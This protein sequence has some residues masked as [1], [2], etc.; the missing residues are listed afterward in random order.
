MTEHSFEIHHSHRD[1]T[2][3]WLRPAV[4]GASDGLVSNLALIA[5]VAGGASAA[6][7][8]SSAVV[9][10]GL[11]GLVAGACS[12][13]VGEYV[14]VASQSELAQAE[15]EL[16]RHEL[17]ARPEAE[18]AELA[19]TFERRGLSRDLA[20]Q[21]AEELSQDSEAAL[22]VHVREELGVDMHDLPSPY[23]ASVSSLLSF[24]VGALVPLLPYLLGADT[25]LPALVLSAIGLFAVGVLVSRVTVRSW[26]FSGVRQLVLGVAAA[27]IT[28]VI[29]SAVGSGV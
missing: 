2:G 13:A 3:G 23:T 29:G 27:G 15:I 6:G 17:K 12:M 14:S 25:L 18:Q 28:F 24:S 19:G 9:I 8:D 11:A 21:V 5:G 22:E 1:V 26:I 16:E 4:F 10:A 7:V 20:Q